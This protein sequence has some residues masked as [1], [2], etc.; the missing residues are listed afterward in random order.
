MSKFSKL[1]DRY[2]TYD[3][4]FGRGSISEWR[5][6]FEE[7]M[8]FSE[9]KKLTKNLDPLVVMGFDSMPNLEELK[10]RFRKLMMTNHPDKGGDHLLCKQ[11]IA[12]FTLLER[13]I[14]Q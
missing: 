6:I 13:R 7:R 11:I 3:D 4:S 8:N 10:N 12:S 2:K 5:S 14:P 1:F 9:A